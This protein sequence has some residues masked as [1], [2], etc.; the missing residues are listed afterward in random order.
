MYITRDPT[1]RHTA[2]S[3]LESKTVNVQHVCTVSKV[4]ESFFFITRLAATTE[5]RSFSH[6]SIAFPVVIASS[7]YCASFANSSCGLFPRKYFLHILVLLHNT[8]CLA[9][10]EDPFAPELHKAPL[11]RP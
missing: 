7:F 11:S 2:L 3:F 8:P 1:S 5:T 6:E 4:R 10:P 9:H